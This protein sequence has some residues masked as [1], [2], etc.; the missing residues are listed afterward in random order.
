MNCAA[1]TQCTVTV[2]KSTSTTIGF[3]FGLESEGLDWIS[4]GFDVS[5]SFTTGDQYGCTGITNQEVCVWY[6]ASYTSYTVQ[7]VHHWPCGEGTSRD[8]PVILNSPDKDN[9]DTNYYCVIG[10]CRSEGDGYWE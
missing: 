3:S 4:G 10:P 9:S 6:R 7:K 2:E 5:K 8:D 1:G